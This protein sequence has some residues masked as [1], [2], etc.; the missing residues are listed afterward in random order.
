MHKQDRPE[1]E[2]NRIVYDRG[3]QGVAKDL[4]GTVSVIPYKRSKRHP[5]TREQRRHN[6]WINS[7]KILIEHP[8]GRLKRYAR[9]SDPYDG[10]AAQFDRE[11]NVIIRLVNLHL[12]DYIRKKT[13]P[14]QQ[15]TSVDWERPAQG[16]RYNE[17]LWGVLLRCQDAY[18]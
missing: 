1:E 16:L 7:E 14:R 5:L 12:W 3:H 2:K 15:Q 17:H 6:S 10:T 4:P 18:A 13:P 8:I 9:I 11:F